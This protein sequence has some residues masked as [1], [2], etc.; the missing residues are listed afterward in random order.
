MKISAGIRRV[1]DAFG[2]EKA[3]E[4]AVEAGFDCVDISLADMEKDENCLFLQPDALEQCRRLRAYAES[5]GLDINQTHAPVKGNHAQWQAGEKDKVIRRMGQSILVSG[6]LGA[7]NVVVHPLQYWNYLNTD[8]KEGLQINLEYYGAL[9]PYAQEAGVKIA[10]ENMWQNHKYNKNITLSVCSSPYEHRE[11]VDACN[12]MAPVFTAC[13]DVGH[14]VLTGHDPAKSIEV[15]GD[16]LQALHIHDVDGIN[17]N[18][19]CP[20]TLNVNFE[21]IMDSLRKVGYPG[22]FNLETTYYF[23]KFK[24]EHYDVALWNLATACKIITK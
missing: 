12:A 11:Y 24:P 8:P 4:M 16:R 15:L 6:A 21:A 13:L 14:C 2:Y 19:T 10:I 3:F 17:D 18:H 7:R 20:L 5:L 1:A 9:I 22:E 23:L